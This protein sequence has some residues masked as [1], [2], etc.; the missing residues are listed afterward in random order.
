MKAT[1]LIAI[2]AD[3]IADWGDL[4]VINP[5]QGEKCDFTKLK[6]DSDDNSTWIELE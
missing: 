3:I 4:E 6:V 1:K 2:L 5:Y